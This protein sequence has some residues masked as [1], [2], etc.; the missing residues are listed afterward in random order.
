MEVGMK[1]GKWKL[2]AFT[3]GSIVAACL[4]VYLL[5]PRTHIN[6]ENYEKIQIGMSLAEVE[7]I[8]GGPARDESSG[9]LRATDRG[10]DRHVN[11]EARVTAFKASFIFFSF[12]DNPPA[13]ESQIWI[14]DWLMV[15]ADLD[16]EGRV[17]SRSCLRVR[18][19][20]ENRLGVLRR[21][22]GV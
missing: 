12:D 21:W 8:L 3:L 9:P 15:R 18:P 10:D 11:P 20:V 4:G 1:T 22:L 7:Q 13:P 19:A 17:N 14:T 2:L 16:S 5:L 6:H